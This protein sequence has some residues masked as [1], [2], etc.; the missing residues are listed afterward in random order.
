MATLL[1][2]ATY[3]ASGTGA[4]VATGVYRALRGSLSVTAFSGG[5]ATFGEV[6]SLRLQ[7]LDEGAAH[8]VEFT[9]RHES[10]DSLMQLERS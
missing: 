5:A 10:V 6:G 4:S 9:D 7:L 2:L 8:P 1:P 3:S